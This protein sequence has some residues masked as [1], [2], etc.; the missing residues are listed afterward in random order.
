MSEGDAFKKYLC[1][2]FFLLPSTLFD[3]TFGRRRQRRR[4]EKKAAFFKAQPKAAVR[5]SV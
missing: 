2:R 4:G 1:L 3:V 5:S